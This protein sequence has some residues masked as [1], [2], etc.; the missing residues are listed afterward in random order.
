MVS[1]QGTD[2]AADMG[3]RS[4]SGG[5]M[6]GVSV[7]RRD[8][9]RILRVADTGFQPAT[10]S[11]RSGTFSICCPKARPAGGRASATGERGARRRDASAGF[12]QLK[13]G[14]AAAGSGGPPFVLTFRV[15]SSQ[16]RA[17]VPFGE[18]P[19]KEQ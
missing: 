9:D 4:E 5:W 17:T 10:I 2:F 15:G 16:E 8:G 11:A 7:F 18:C 6:P 13:T 1:H 12:S 14:M 19:Q 3:Y